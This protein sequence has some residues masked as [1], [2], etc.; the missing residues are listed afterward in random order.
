M[1]NC[2]LG[3]DELEET[4]GYEAGVN[5]QSFLSDASAAWKLGWNEADLEWSEA[6]IEF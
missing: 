2:C 3:D 6:E 1:N 4:E 5:N